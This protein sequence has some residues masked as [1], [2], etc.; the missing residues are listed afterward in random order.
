MD[1]NVEQQL[2]ILPGGYRDLF[3]RARSVFEADERVRAMWV[4]GAMARLAADAGSDLDISLAIDDAAFEAFTS[5]WPEWLARITPTVSAVPIVNGSFYALTPTCERIDVISE[6]ASAAAHSVVQRR[7]VVFDRDGLTA[8]LAEPTDP[9]PDR[10]LIRY[11]I[12]EP[13]RQ[14]ANF[15]TVLVREDWLLGVVAVQQVHS[16]LY[17]L[18][19]EAN[20]PQPPTGPKQYSCK[21]SS[22]HRALLEALPVPQPER[23]SVLSARHAALSV[24]VAEAPRIAADHGVEYPTALSDAVLG[25]LERAGLGIRVSP[26]G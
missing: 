24:L 18:F 4:H 13:L 25:F 12:E 1:P 20:K 19:V 7:L 14:A 21:L 23:T 10:G 9:G 17:S 11:F 16:F 26:T 5:E 15:P 6:P 3:A 8:T 2:A 22:R